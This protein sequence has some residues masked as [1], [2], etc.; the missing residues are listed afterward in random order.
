[1]RKLETA[2]I[3]FKDMKISVDRKLEIINLFDA[4]YFFDISKCN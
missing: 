2:I 3:N 1:M 4:P